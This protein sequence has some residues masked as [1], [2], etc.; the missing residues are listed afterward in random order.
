MSKIEPRI[1]ALYD[2]YKNGLKEFSIYLNSRGG[3][4]N[5]FSV[6][7]RKQMFPIIFQFLID[8]NICLF[9]NEHIYY[10]K[11]IDVNKECIL[12][13]YLGESHTISIPELQIEMPNLY[14]TGMCDANDYVNIYFTVFE[15]VIQMIH[16]DTFNEEEI[17]TDEYND[18]DLPF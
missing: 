7:T 1:Q 11:S 5:K 12:A 17:L 14:M 4:F 8:K 16:Q 18:K 6:A 15:L 13:K 9:I 2:E 3:D 10:V